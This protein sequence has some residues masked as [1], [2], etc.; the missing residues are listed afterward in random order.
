VKNLS[1][2]DNPYGIDEPLMYYNKTDESHS[3]RR[4]SVLVGNSFHF[5]LE[6]LSTSR[7]L[8]QLKAIKRKENLL[9]E[10]GQENRI[11]ELEILILKKKND[12]EKI[13]N[14]IYELYK[15]IESMKIEVEFLKTYV[16]FNRNKEI[17]IKSEEVLTPKLKNL[18]SMENVL[19]IKQM[20]SV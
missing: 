11:S 12:K 14:Q 16:L 15:E 8:A 10:S 7:S 6:K 5:I 19:K 17:D 18:Q 2:N 3:T 4:E 1:S 9:R 20:H 13:V